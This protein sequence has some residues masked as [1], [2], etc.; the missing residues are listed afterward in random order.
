MR[1]LPQE[2]EW[3]KRVA[4][5]YTDTV[6]DCETARYHRQVAEWLRELKD[7]REA[8]HPPVQCDRLTIATAMRCPRLDNDGDT[9]LRGR[10]LPCGKDKDPT[11]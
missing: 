2:I 9:C 8:E 11:A 4:A 7:R 3:H 1:D 6:P 5:S 10:D